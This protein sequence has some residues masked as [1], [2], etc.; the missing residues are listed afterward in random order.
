MT[1]DLPSQKSDWQN[2][3][4]KLLHRVCKSFDA[5][6]QRG[7]PACKTINKISRRYQGRLY[8]ANPTR[9]LQLSPISLRRAFKQWRLGG[10]LP[11]AIRLKFKP[12]PGIPAPVLIRFTEFCAR[13]RQSSLQAAWRNFQR[14]WSGNH[15]HY[16]L[17]QV[18]RHFGA[19][20]FYRIQTSLRAIETEQGK[21]AELRLNI[22]ADLHGRL[23]AQ[24]ALTRSKRAIN[25]E[26]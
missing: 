13:R 3:R 20:N 2:E 1:T 23:P 16:S 22:I 10:R 8:S 25:F 6:L 4:S 21:L 12:A 17:N 24:R 26:I 9:R 15:A 18:R 11:S 5:A 14:T 19:V 7:E